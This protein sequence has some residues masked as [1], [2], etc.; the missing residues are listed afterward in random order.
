MKQLTVVTDKGT[1]PAMYTVKF[2]RVFEQDAPA[3]ATGTG[4]GFGHAIN[5]YTGSSTISGIRMSTTAP[6]VQT[7][8]DT[9]MAFMLTGAVITSNT[10]QDCSGST[11]GGAT[12][13]AQ[14]GFQWGTTLSK[15]AWADTITSCYPQY[16]AITYSPTKSYDM[17]IFSTG[18]P[19]QWYLYIK[20]LYTG[21]VMTQPRSGI[22]SSFLKT[23]AYNTSVF[24]ETQSHTPNGNQFNTYPSATSTISTNSGSTWF[25]WESGGRNDQDCKAV[26]HF[27]PYDSNKEIISGNLAGGGSATYNTV[28]MATYYYA[29]PC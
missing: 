1:T 16:P 17:K 8:A 29:A 2:V 11:Q 24:L 12:Y 25:N 6:S 9:G 23:S 13:F 18:T 19:T 14:V 20:N 7:T 22:T 3:Q 5:Y 26:N 27:Y 4:S 21:E 28:R 10:S 15:V